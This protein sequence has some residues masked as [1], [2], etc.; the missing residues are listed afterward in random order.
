MTLDI[1]KFDAG[2]V[3]G[4]NIGGRS[5]TVPESMVMTPL[6]AAAVLRFTAPDPAKVKPLEPVISEEIV[7]CLRS[8]R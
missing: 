5:V 6:T 8:A 2:N 4:E 7:G 1:A 3:V